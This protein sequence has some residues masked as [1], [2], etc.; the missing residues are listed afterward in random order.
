MDIEDLHFRSKSD[1]GH[2]EKDSKMDLVNTESFVDNLLTE[3]NNTDGKQTCD[4]M[5]HRIDFTSSKDGVDTAVLGITGVKSRNV[6]TDETPEITDVKVTTEDLLSLAIEQRDFQEDST[7]GINAESNEFF[8]DGECWEHITNWTEISTEQDDTGSSMTVDYSDSS[9]FCAGS[10]NVSIGDTNSLQSNSWLIHRQLMEPELRTDE[11]NLVSCDSLSPGLQNTE[12]FDLGN[13]DISMV[14][15][16]SLHLSLVSDNNLL[17]GAVGRGPSSSH[18]K[19]LAMAGADWHMG[20]VPVK[21]LQLGAVNVA[22]LT[23]G[24]VGISI[25]PMVSAGTIDINPFTESIGMMPMESF[26]WET[27]STDSENFATTHV[28]V[29]SMTSEGIKE[30]WHPLED[31]LYALGEALT[32]L[33]KKLEGFSPRLQEAETLLNDMECSLSQHAMHINDIMS[34]NTALAKRIHQL[35]EQMNREKEHQLFHRD[36][37]E[38]A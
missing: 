20:S 35:E 19:N 11:I 3:E 36:S 24:T 27:I 13:A 30:R 32:S 7:A 8:L 18:H 31:R 5:E 9:T 37:E 4:I 34:E 26:D 6:V 22:S 29:D 1:E 25:I 38:D 15:M 2:K 14:P 17:L 12:T 33:D 23:L 16:E 21:C 28:N 10:L